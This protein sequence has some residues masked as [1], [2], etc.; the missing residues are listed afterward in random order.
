MMCPVGC[1]VRLVAYVVIIVAWDEVLCHHHYDRVMP[2]SLALRLH[3]DWSYDC[4][5]VSFA[6]MVR[7]LAFDYITLWYI[8]CHITMCSFLAMVSF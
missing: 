7:Y 5:A 8:E 4:P 3:F 1:D 6:H 2:S